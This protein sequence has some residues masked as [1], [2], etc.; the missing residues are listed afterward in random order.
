M[1]G[2]YMYGI[3]YKSRFRVSGSHYG[4]ELA[5]LRLNRWSWLIAERRLSNI[6]LRIVSWIRKGFERITR[7]DWARDGGRGVQPTKTG[8]VRSCW[9]LM[10]DTKRRLNGLALESLCPLETNSA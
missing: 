9:L 5:S 4:V 8:G 10:R 2:P 6:V 1:H 7:G 3:N